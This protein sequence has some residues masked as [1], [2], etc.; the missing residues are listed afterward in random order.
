MR[1]FVSFGICLAEEENFLT[2]IYGISWS[3]ANVLTSAWGLG[4]YHII[5]Q[6]RLR[7]ASA[8]L[9]SLA[10][11]FTADIHKIWL[12]MKTDTIVIS[13]APLDIPT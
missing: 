5:E 4:S 9:H 3:Y 6:R 8:E 13:Q 10:R 1:L 2:M 12:Y 7:Q 11:T